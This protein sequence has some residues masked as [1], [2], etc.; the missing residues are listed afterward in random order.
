M[1]KINLV[2][3]L[4]LTAFM[5]AQNKNKEVLF[6]IDNTPY[7]TDEFIRVYQK[8]LD[9]VKDDSQKDLNNY[10]D[11]F[12]AYKL[13]IQKAHKLNLH[14]DTKFQKELNSYREQLAKKYLTDSKVTDELINEAIER[15]KFEVKCSHI[16]IQFPNGDANDTI[17]ALKKI[18]DIKNQVKAGADFN[19]L[20]SNLS[21]DPSA[22]EN[23]GNLGY[24]SVFR[25]IY[26]FETAAFNTPVGEVSD[27]VKTQFGYHIIYVHDKRPNR[28][29]V[30]VAH[31]ML[32]NFGDEKKYEENED[33]INDI[34]QKLL[35][36]EDF[37]SLA[38]Q[39]SD[40]KTTAVRGGALDKFSSGDLASEEFENVA[41]SLKD[42]EFSKPFKTAYG[43]HIAK[44]I[45]K[46]PAKP[47]EEL[48]KDFTVKIERD[49]RSRLISESMNKKL[50]KKY[51]FKV[52]DANYRGIFT[53]VTDSVYYGTWKKPLSFNTYAGK[54][55]TIENRTINGE[56]FL[57][58]LEEQQRYRDQ[59]KPL[60][61]WYSNQ[62]QKF[63]DEQLNK[64]YES[65]LENEFEEFAHIMQEYKEGLLLFD[66]MEKE[67]WDRAKNDSIGLQKLFDANAHKY[68]WNTRYKVQ[69]F[70]SLDK[71]VV[72]QAKKLLQQKI[73]IEGIK[74]QLNVD[75]KINIM[76]N[77]GLFEK[78][79]QVFP[80]GY[81]YNLGLS[82]ILEKNKY[83]FLVN[84]LEI[85]PQSPKSFD[86]A[87]GRVINEYQQ[88]LESQWVDNL[89]GE[90]KVS[91][92]NN[93]F[94]KVKKQFQ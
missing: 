42:N 46:H 5:F 79:H 74:E 10:L 41:F 61:A 15:S 55:L 73:D 8:N 84:L 17:E 90:F 59:T 89:K 63:V 31:I 13:K 47:F 64:Y 50:R 38:E 3:L 2:V 23:Q 81:Q 56:Q 58:Y 86:E 92:N 80:E 91:V 71:S 62:Y 12:V 30:T 7:H 75:N 82:E 60:A 69:I 39:F 24:F 9:L 77:E 44:L 67:I 37:G 28:G 83:F 65:Q 25:M 87:K 93:V 22:R 26:P 19:K 45:Q 54:F 88:L 94:E 21:E 52:D 43:W 53:L 4:M 48:K 68:Q 6:T 40:D 57:N 72:E 11:L 70:S 51:K 20:A 14:L 32:A 66:L 76:V 27:V 1:K 85:V 33:K 16:L 35:Q 78:D 49:D 18:N 34:Y 29:E 36:G